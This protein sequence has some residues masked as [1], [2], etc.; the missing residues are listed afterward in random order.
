MA[1]PNR[2][3]HKK[4]RPKTETE[5][6]ATETKETDLSVIGLLLGHVFQKTDL[7]FQASVLFLGYPIR[8][9]LVLGQ[10]YQPIYS[11]RG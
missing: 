11:T 1:P 4:T 9:I 6:T 8:P 10:Y 2:G 3:G 5:K 7:F